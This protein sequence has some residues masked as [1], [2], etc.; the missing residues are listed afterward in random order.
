MTTTEP[1][2]AG[3]GP[4]TPLWL[5]RSLDVREGRDPL[6][7]QTTTQDRLT[8]ILLPGILEL[9]RRARYF[10]FHA[11]LLHTYRERKFKAES[12]ALSSFI[13]AR[14]W[15]YGLAVLRCPHDC[16]SSPVGALS[17]RGVVAQAGPYPRGESVKSALGGYGLYYRSPMA[18][19]RLV[20]RAGTPLGEGPIP[21]DVLHDT[22]RA[23]GLVETFSAA[24]TDTSYVKHWMFTSDPLPADVLD[25]LAETA[26]LCQLR[27]RPEERNAVHAALFTIDEYAGAAIAPGDAGAAPEGE[28]VPPLVLDA[29]AAVAQR[30]ASFAHYLSLI[31]AAPTIVGDESAF[32]ESLWSSSAARSDAHRVV[33]GQWAGL[34]AKDVWQDALCSIWAEFGRAG[35]DRARATGEG[36][37]WTETGDLTRSLVAGPPPLDAAAPT[38]EIAAAVEGGQVT[39]PGV[40]GTLAA[41]SLE[42]L[43][44]ATVELNTASSGL[45][46]LLELH[47]RAYGRADPGWTQ[48][49]TVRSAWQP[50]VVD[51]LAALHTHLAEGPTV[52]DTL[53]YLVQ[54]YVIRVHERIAYSKLPE[55][56]FRFRWEDGRMR[57]YDNGIGR[58]PLAAIRK[59]PLAL[60][61]L[62]LGLCTRS[63][64]DEAQLTA[65]GT[66]FI[67]EVFG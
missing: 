47:R 18:E 33:A 59:D 21:I 46:V 51:V 55:D 24:V 11:W 14:E 61:S 37:T 8:P 52:A 20:A 6:G 50:S 28:E 54:R 43:R 67:A 10:S 32:R 30:R 39:L 26:C 34:V 5:Q 66:A 3:S 48:T 17:L 57:F 56:T 27:A 1:A 9:S 25:E 35:L 63:D 19:L 22:D 12:S 36:L 16:G 49:A 2:P 58:F 62:D 38:V 15:D 7:L 64:S 40:D 31:E 45:I 44:A 13:K 42:S 29:E 53:W 4:G 23:R 41:T 65:R 60:I